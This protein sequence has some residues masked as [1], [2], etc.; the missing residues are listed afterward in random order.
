M[1]L[2]VTLFLPLAA[3]ALMLLL[4]ARAPASRA[5]WT[6]LLATIATCLAS[7]GLAADFA[8][9]PPVVSL[10]ARAP[11]H[12]QMEIKQPWFSLLAPLADG[13]ARTIDLEFFLGVDGIG[14]I[15]ILATTVLC[16]SSVLVS[17][18][19][20]TQR[21]SEFY[22]FLLLLEFGLIGVFCAFD[23]VLFYVFY[24]F[25]LIP[26]FLMVGMWGGASR[27]QAAS[28][29]FTYLFSGS[30]ITLVGIVALGWHAVTATDLTTPFSLPDLSAALSLKPMPMALQ[31]GIFLALA[32]GFVVKAPLLPFHTWLPQF[33]SEAPPAASVLLLKLGVFGFL[34]LLLPLVPTA[35]WVWGV[36]LIAMLSVAG[37][38]YGS[39]CALVQ[40]DLKKLLAYSSVAH[41]GFC[42]LG[43]FALNQE[44]ISGGVI[45]MMNLGLSTGALF[46][47]VGMVAE[48]YQTRSLSQFGGLAQRLPRLASMMVFMTFASIGLPGLNGFVGEILAL[49]GMFGAT[50]EW[51]R[52]YAAIAAMGIVLGA[53]YMLAALRKAFF[54]PLQEPLVV[55]A[56]AGE[57]IGDLNFREMAAIAPLAILCLAIGLFP[58]PV[59][60]VIQPDVRA[61]TVNLD[62]HTRPAAESIEVQENESTV[63]TWPA[64]PVS[65]AARKL[66]E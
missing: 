10:D 22:A 56:P 16:F 27:R 34:R 7:F 32:A 39:L 45:Q 13:N 20:V 58:Q 19:S 25:T 38:I 3:A 35:C 28:Q 63:M 24:E 11:I 53:W 62:S 40:D 2:L 42:F 15:M 44:G 49:L 1:L 66:G 4:D 64:T 51:G 18:N 23:L 59:L 65:T 8:K 55:G 57:V 30:L 26:T 36:P 41:V 33:H 61:L 60:D 9:I 21:A 29:Y 46:C 47:L 5:R 48:R 52:A 14:L 54:G 50:H 17:W 6:A 37:I 31:T 43:L 12:A